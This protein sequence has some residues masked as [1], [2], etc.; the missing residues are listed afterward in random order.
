MLLELHILSHLRT[1]RASGLPLRY[2]G[3]AFAPVAQDIVCLTEAGEDVVGQGVGEILVE[4][5]VTD[6]HPVVDGPV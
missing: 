5:G 4:R 6:K 1:A 3:Y 2:F